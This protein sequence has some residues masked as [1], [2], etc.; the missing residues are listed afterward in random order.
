M[1][2]VALYGMTPEEYKP[3]LLFVR[4]IGMTIIGTLP[5]AAWNYRRQQHGGLVISYITRQEVL[6]DGR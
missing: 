2:M 4:A 1:G 5:N 3:A 6:N